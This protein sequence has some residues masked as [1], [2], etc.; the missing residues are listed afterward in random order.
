[1]KA[2]WAISFPIN[3]NL[4]CSK[5]K[6]NSF[7]NYSYKYGNNLKGKEMKLYSVENGEFIKQDF[8]KI[9]ILK[10]NKKNKFLIISKHFIDTTKLNSIY[11]KSYVE[12]MLKENKDTLHIGTVSE[13]KTK[14]KVLFEKLTKNDSLSIQFLDGKKLGKKV[15][16]PVE[17]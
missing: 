14:H 13:F 15:T 8:S 11:L 12:K 9:K 1:M 6:N 17:W 10:K 3:M 7:R 2:I 16:V 5:S 4:D